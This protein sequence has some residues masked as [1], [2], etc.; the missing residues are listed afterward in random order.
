MV[1]GGE[2][3]VAIIHPAI[4]ANGGWIDDFV[5][6][7]AP[8]RFFKIGRG[9][10][11]VDWHRRGRTTTS[12]EWRLHFGQAYRAMRTRPDVLIANFPPLTFAACVWKTLMF[13]PT[14]IIGWSF[15]FG[16]G[17]KSRLAPVF[18]RAFRRAHALI[19]HSREEIPEY[20]RAFGLDAAKFRFIPFQQGDIDTPPAAE[21]FDVVAM[22]SAGR[23]YATLC[24]ALRDTPLSA[25]IIAKP[26]A[27]A[28]VDVPPNV[29][30]RAGLTMEECRALSAA[31]P[32]AA[33]AI[34]ETTNAAGQATLLTAMAQGRAI[35]ATRCPGTAD[36]LTDGEDALLVEPGDAAG[37][38]DAL[39][40]LAG[41]EDLRNRQSVAAQQRWR[42]DYSDQAAGRNLRDLLDQVMEHD[43]R[44]LQ[45]HPEV[46]H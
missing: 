40:R 15:N 24:E 25:L 21:R 11:S 22:G 26:E 35:V 17:S 9:G 1:A 33:V 36:Y 14:R 16:G 34:A 27:L 39:L 13:S 4:D 31:A 8:Y 5:D 6:P 41:D 3:S 23:D 7:A 20:A 12:D 2:V 43:E 46:K 45:P 18:G 38:R 28:G 44:G 37:L 30:V 10:R 32:I 29:Q 19:T 42:R